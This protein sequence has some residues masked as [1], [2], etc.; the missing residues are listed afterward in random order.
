MVIKPKIRGF[1]CLTSH[2]V[3]C[4]AHI[5]QQITYVREKGRIPNGPKNALVIGGSTGYGLASRI[6]AAFGCGAS[7]L[8][9]FFEKEPSERK[10]GTAGWYNSAAFGRA[11]KAEGLYARSLN[12]DA[13]SDEIKNQTIDIVKNDLG[14]IDLVV[15]SVASPRRTHPKTGEIQH[16]TLKPIGET[17]EGMTLDTDKK[18]VKP[19]TIEPATDQDVVDTVSVMGAE[20]WEM[21]MDALEAAG[22]LADGCRAIAF[23][24][25][26]SDATWP[27]YRAG[28]IGKA[29][30]D[31]E[32]GAGKIN[33]RLEAR[34]GGAHI[35][36]MKAIVTQ[37]SSA[38]PV[39]PLYISLLY[40]VMKEKGLHEGCIEQMQRLFATRLYADGGAVTDQD[41]LIR[42]DDWEMRDDVQRAVAEWWPNVTSDNLEDVT[43]FDGYQADF[44]KLFGFGLRGVDYEADVDQM[45]RLET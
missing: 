22:V 27:I 30:E 13:F 45:V 40:K 24:Y 20:D 26:G 44:L 19:I 8:G 5:G 32:R 21:W 42:L 9:V 38:I 43:D 34:G 41:G 29:K 4:E 14:T 16:S 7:T 1:F 12:G 37:S 23:T 11:A 17:Y 6:T 15:Y 2:P 31:L 33:Q 3:G 35:G 36:V 10:P 28:T 18:I 25:I 39:V